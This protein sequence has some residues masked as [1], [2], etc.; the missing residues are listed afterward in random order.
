MSEGPLTTP[1]RAHFRFFQS[2]DFE[3]TGIVS[4]HHDA[5]SSLR[6]SRG[7]FEDVYGHRAEHEEI[8]LLLV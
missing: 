3:S 5:K 6:V 1:R 8:P 2:V 4:G 7:G